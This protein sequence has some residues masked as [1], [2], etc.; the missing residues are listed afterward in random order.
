MTR[1]LIIKC[2]RGHEQ[3]VEYD[4]AYSRNEIVAHGVIWCGGRLV[5][6]RSGGEDLVWPGHVCSFDDTPEETENPCGAK[7]GFSIAESP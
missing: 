2:E 1:T 4:G 7:L 6:V 5:G 3:R